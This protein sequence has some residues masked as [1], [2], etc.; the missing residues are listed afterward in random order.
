E[1]IEQLEHPLAVLDAELDGGGGDVADLGLLDGDLLV[2]EGLADSLEELGVAGDLEVLAVRPQVV[3]AGL[4]GDL[5]EP[6]LGDVPSLDEEL[7]LGVEQ[8]ADA[9]GGAEVAAAD[10]ERLAELAGGAVAVVGQGRAH[11]GD[12]AGA[13]PL[14]HHLLVILGPELAGRL[15]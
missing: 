13:V 3:G 7:A 4:E 10:L 11:D 14:V 9:A 6:V 8:V 2:E 12:A 15:L 5:H 1:D